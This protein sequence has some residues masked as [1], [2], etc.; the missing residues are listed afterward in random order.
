MRDDARRLGGIADELSD[1]ARGE[2]IE[3][4]GVFD[5][6]DPTRGQSACSPRRADQRSGESGEGVGAA[7]DRGCRRDRRLRIAR[8]QLELPQ[9]LGQP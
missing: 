8:M 3:L 5:S 1:D 9:R 4:S 2:R 7:R 6:G